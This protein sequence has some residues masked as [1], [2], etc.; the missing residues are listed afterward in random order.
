MSNKV[1][2]TIT[3]PTVDNDGL[4][5]PKDHDPLPEVRTLLGGQFDGYTEHESRGVWTDPG[6]V[7]FAEPGVVFTI[8]TD[9]AGARDVL[10]TIAARLTDDYGQEAVYLT[11]Q[12]INV[13]LFE[14]NSIVLNTSPDRSTFDPLA[15]GV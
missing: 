3:V 14:A 11:S 7:V 6:G 8:D 15:Q 4:E 10:N 2:F 9:R 1:R 13:E 12:P 5:W